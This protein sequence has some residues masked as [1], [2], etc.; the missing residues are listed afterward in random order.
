[1]TEA[2]KKDPRRVRLS[3]L[4]AEAGKRGID[5]EQLRN[6]LAPA[7][8]GKRLSEATIPELDRLMRFIGAPGRRGAEA[9]EEAPAS[10]YKERFDELGLREGM[11][12]PRQLRM[13]EAMWMDVSRMPT[14]VAR[15]VALKHFL[16]RVIGVDEMR[17]IEAW[18][19][20][21]VVRAIQGMKPRR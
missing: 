5:G 12:T 1:M 14:H 18:Q 10:G 21:K 4:F 17:F 8:L 16:R 19:V 3:A 20:Q 11:A 13:I 15:E 6:E 7:Q 2:Q 9:R